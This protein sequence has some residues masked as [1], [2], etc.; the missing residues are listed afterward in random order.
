MTTS[1]FPYL[2]CLWSLVVITGCESVE[3]R[4][5]VQEYIDPIT[6]EKTHTVTAS[7]SVPE[8]EVVSFPQNY[9]PSDE[10]AVSKFPWDDDLAAWRVIA[11]KNDQADGME[12]NA[13]DG[14]MRLVI[15]YK[16][17]S[18]AVIESDD[19]GSTVSILDENGK[20]TLSRTGKS[21]ESAP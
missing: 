9:T 17:G 16:D 18:Q 5:E 12:I 2:T 4:T 21:S 19:T 7:F 20:C 8:P 15:R 6:D 3:C 14:Q 10:P 1:R 11:S 13:K